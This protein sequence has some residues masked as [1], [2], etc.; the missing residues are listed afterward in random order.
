MSVKKWERQWEKMV[1]DELDKQG[2]HSEKTSFNISSDIKRLRDYDWDSIISGGQVVK[3][4]QP[5]TK[6]ARLKLQAVSSD[7]LPITIGTVEYYEPEVDY[8]TAIVGQLI[9][10]ELDYARETR[11][12]LEFN[13]PVIL[14]DAS[15]L[16]QKLLTSKTLKLKTKASKSSSG[17]N[18]W[19]NNCATWI[20]VILMLIIGFALCGA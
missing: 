20:F 1:M 15:S 18:T 6:G 2:I 8:Q 11:Y 7:D 16:P 17:F 10:K 3:V 13:Q 14:V 19:G 4:V 9:E 12:C 5:K